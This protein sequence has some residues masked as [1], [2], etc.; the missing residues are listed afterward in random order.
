MAE[1]RSD[2]NVYAE[3]AAEVMQMY[4]GRLDERKSTE[5]INQHRA[6]NEIERQLRLKGLQA[7]GTRYSSAHEDAG[8]MVS[9]PAK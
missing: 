2:A 4:R 1:G 5:A 3:A 9:L 8:S 7:G 6:V